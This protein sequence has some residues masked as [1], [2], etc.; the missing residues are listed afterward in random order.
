M[1]HWDKTTPVAP[2]HEEQGL[3]HRGY[4]WIGWA[5]GVANAAVLAAV[6]YLALSYETQQIPSA[7]NS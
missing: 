6:I 3:S 7:E 4:F 1:N 2:P 5:V